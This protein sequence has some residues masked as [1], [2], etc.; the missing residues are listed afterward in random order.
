MGDFEHSMIETLQLV[1]PTFIKEVIFLVLKEFVLLEKIFSKNFSQ[2]N[3][4]KIF[5][6]I[7]NT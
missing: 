3:M 7:P 4:R 2:M 6:S 5:S 1:F